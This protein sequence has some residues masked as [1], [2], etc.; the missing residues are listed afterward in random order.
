ML[1][2]SAYQT[3]RNQL[4]ELGVVSLSWNNL[5]IGAE[6]LDRGIDLT[7]SSGSKLVMRHSG[8]KH[9][10]RLGNSSLNSATAIAVVKNKAAA[11][12]LLETSGVSAPKN[13][14]FDP[15]EARRAWAWAEA[16]VPVV[17]KP[18]DGLM[19]RDVH[20]DISDWESFQTAFDSVALAGDPVLVER[21]NRGRDH[22]VTVIDGRMVAVTHRVSAHVIGD[23]TSTVA[24]L[25]EEKNRLRRKVHKKI[26]ADAVGMVQLRKQ[27]FGLDSVP[28]EGSTVYLR[29][30]AN[31]STGGD[32]FDATD[33]LS[34]EEIAMVESA[35][36]AIPGLRVAGFDVLLPRLEGHDSP[37]II[38]INHNPAV[39]GHHFP[40]DGQPRDAA[41]A[42]LNAMFPST[43]RP[44]AAPAGA[45]VAR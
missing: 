19:G 38:E 24:D 20:V 42:I 39:S 21:F 22:R 29:G 41:G 10:W 3:A 25:I 23:G 2:E 33:D 18:F 16:L 35:A 8:E 17:V 12:K 40:W 15:G 43:H 9:F 36:E 7:G 31:L 32:I 4:R 27:G 37:S 13:Q 30:N 11:S 14:M 26:A 34:S 5:V 1:P 45:A 44:V 28:D 6:A